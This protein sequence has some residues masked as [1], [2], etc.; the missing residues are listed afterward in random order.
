G[1]LPHTL[2]LDEPTPYVDWSAGSVRLLTER[3]AWPE[4]GRPRRAGVSSFGVSGT[5]AHTILEHVPEREPERAPGPDAKPAPEPAATP[6]SAASAPVS[7]T[8]L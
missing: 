5:N 1:E 3:T 2:H 6:T 8:H 7:Y 4:T